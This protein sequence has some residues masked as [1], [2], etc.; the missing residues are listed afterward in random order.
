MARTTRE[1]LEILSAILL[2]L[3]SVATA[4]GAYQATLW[5]GEASALAEAS[6]QARDRNLSE[7]LS[8][9]I[10][11]V[12]DSGKLIELT[13]LNLETFVFPER[14]A[15]IAITQ[16][17]LLQAATPELAAGWAAF[18]ESDYDI[19]FAPLTSIEYEA[20]LYAE[21][22]SLQYV[23]YVADKAADAVGAR[24]DSVT[25][26]ALVF[27]VAL[28]LLGVA[29]VSSSWRLAGWLTS[30]AALA[31]VVGVVIVLLAG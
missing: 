2:G 25:L 5:A 12:D 3:V 19:A 28:F 20:H 10:A 18:V 27:A 24:A 22:Q 17:A 21:V 29:G 15:E 30:G 26:G 9:E 8:T 1:I 23:G 7:Y 16:E 11:A 6:Q 14:A 31:F 13:R 4:F